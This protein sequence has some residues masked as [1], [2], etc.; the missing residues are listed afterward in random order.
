MAYKRSWEKGLRNEKEFS[1]DIVY[2]VKIIPIS[3]TKMLFSKYPVKA[4]WILLA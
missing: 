2:L 3:A 4:V 1:G